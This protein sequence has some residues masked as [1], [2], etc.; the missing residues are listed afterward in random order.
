M[1]DAANRNDG[2]CEP[3]IGNVVELLKTLIDVQR[4]QL[5]TLEQI[6]D[7]SAPI[8]S[9]A[10]DIVQQAILLIE[11]CDANKSE[12]A[13]KLR[14]GRKVMYGRAWDKFHEIC[15]RFQ[16]CQSRTIRMPR[17]GLANSDGSFDVP[18]EQ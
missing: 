6:R 3:S 2:T 4:Q 10:L 9:D 1:T 7:G 5:A 14:I 8:A 18:S 13:R 11:P 16:G 12:I 17:H 15:E